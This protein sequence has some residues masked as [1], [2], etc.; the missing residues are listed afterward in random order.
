[1]LHPSPSPPPSARLLILILTLSLRLAPPS[2]PPHPMAAV[3]SPSTASIPLPSSPHSSRSATPTPSHPYHYVTLH[4]PPPVLLPSPSSSPLCL[5]LSPSK[6]SGRHT[7]VFRTRT[8]P[9]LLPHRL[10]RHPTTHV[11]RRPYS[12][13]PPPLSRTPSRNSPPRLRTPTCQCFNDPGERV[14]RPPPRPPSHHPFIPHQ[15]P[16]R[17]RSSFP[18]RC[19]HPR[20]YRPRIR[21]PST[22]RCCPPSPHPTTHLHLHTSHLPI[23]RRYHL[24]CHSRRCRYLCSLFMPQPDL[25]PSYSV[26]SRRR[27]SFSSACT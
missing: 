18:F 7:Q 16:I 19:L 10:R 8:S 14:P 22:P 1:M 11:H 24:T 27:C 15:C 12:S 5:S 9:F 20:P 26:Y 21:C 23:R 13:C 2:A 25:P 17:R 6:S 3:S 4:L